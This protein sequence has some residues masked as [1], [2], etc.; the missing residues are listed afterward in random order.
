MCG[1]R[2]LIAGCVNELDRLV[3][4]V[5]LRAGE[6]ASARDQRS[7]LRCAAQQLGI[8]AREL[9]QLVGGSVDASALVA[10]CIVRQPFPASVKQNKA[11][12][13]PTVL[14]LLLG[15]RVG[16]VD[17]PTCRAS[18]VV[19]P[20]VKASKKGAVTITN[21][22]QTFESTAG[23]PPLIAKFTSLTFPVGSRL[24][25]LQMQFTSSV[26]VAISADDA[27]GSGMPLDNAASA[28]AARRG[29][30]SAAA[31][32]A[33]TAATPVTATATS[34]ASGELIVKTNEN[35]WDECEGVLL[36]RSLWAGDEKRPLAWPAL[37]NA[38]QLHYTCVQL[39]SS[40][41]A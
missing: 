2:R 27:R 37:C 20:S 4:S 41:I 30:A 16:V 23:A 5:M 40:S 9:A 22:E 17:V 39:V 10:L 8:Y 26:P 7:E 15:A 13:Q 34:E 25:P 3:S 33:H 38:L 21:A 35:Q 14:R 6:I 18:V 1:V 28:A 19:M 31:A 11:V 24:A 32:L 29:K 12:A 36:R